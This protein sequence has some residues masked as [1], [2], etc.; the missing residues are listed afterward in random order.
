[1]AKKAKKVKDTNKKTQHVPSAKSQNGHSTFSTTTL[2][3]KKGCK[4]S[5]VKT[6]AEVATVKPQ[7]LARTQKHMKAPVL[8]AIQEEDAIDVTIEADDWMTLDNVYIGSL[9]PGQGNKG[10]KM[11]CEGLEGSAEED[12][13]DDI[14]DDEIKSMLEDSND[15]ASMVVYKAKHM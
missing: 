9:V 1:M 14:K 4:V 12:N 5:E 8:A 2:T 6:L 7:I 3:T 13:N 11:T 15:A 10:K